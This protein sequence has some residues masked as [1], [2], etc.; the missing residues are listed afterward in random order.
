MF[1][2]LTIISLIL[3][4]VLFPPAALAVISNNAVPGDT[5]YPI[6]R[7]LEDIIFAI[8]SISPISKAW[9]A[10]ARSD[11]RFIEIKTLFAQGKSVDQSL[12]DLVSQTQIAAE[13]ISK[14]E[15]PVK[16]QE[17]IKNLS[18][19]IQ[20]YTQGLNSEQQTIPPATP[21]PISVSK[22][23]SP[24][25]SSLKP[26]PQP[27]ATAQPTSVPTLA[28]PPAGGPAPTPIQSGPTP[29]PTPVSTSVQP[30]PTPIPA[31]S[32][33]SSQID[34]TIDELKHIDQDLHARKSVKFLPKEE[35]KEDQQVKNTHRNDQKESD[36][37][38]KDENKKS[39]K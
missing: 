9:F 34:K 13:Q 19:N 17:L 20:K 2:L 7:S 3:A 8:A 29:V 33:D 23:S 28:P 6:K 22:T 1:K 16:K 5:T 30:G 26:T 32:L 14:V 37:G 25:V 10:A 35:K 4:L 31:G 18:S 21:G 12:Q 36:K 15:D 11:R 39:P 38:K 27:V 24:V